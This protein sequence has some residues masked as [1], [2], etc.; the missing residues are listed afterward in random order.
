MWA[1]DHQNNLVN[2]NT[3]ARIH[4]VAGPKEGEA[5]V[6]FTIKEQ[7]SILMIGTPESCALYIGN[8]MCHLVINSAGI[9]VG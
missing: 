2:L 9:N 6:A 8:L 4:R 5:V 1:R 7:R 3:G